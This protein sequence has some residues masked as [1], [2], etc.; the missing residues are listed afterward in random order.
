MQL[1]PAT[2][3]DMA[4]KVG[5]RVTVDELSDPEI[6]IHLGFHYLSL[7][8]SE[9][10]DDTVAVLAAYNAGPTN[11]RSWRQGYSL[12]PEKIP[13]PETRQFVKKVLNAHT[14]L[15]RFQKVKNAIEA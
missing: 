14:W 3:L 4:K 11:V 5:R 13:Y 7:L 8:R 6:N 12:T 1:M 10:K 15:K 2:A 9:F